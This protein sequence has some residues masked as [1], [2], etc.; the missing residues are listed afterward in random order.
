MNESQKTCPLCR[1]DKPLTEFYVRPSRVRA[2]GSPSYQHGCKAC[3]RELARNWRALNPNSAKAI[4]R[5]A[6]LRYYKRNQAAIARRRKAR[7]EVPW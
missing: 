3:R 6:S 5:A 4:G 1:A 7:K 2:D